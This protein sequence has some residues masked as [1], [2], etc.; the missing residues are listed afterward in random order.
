ML[1]HSVGNTAV[2]QSQ[3]NS[4]LPRKELGVSETSNNIFFRSYFIILIVI[5]AVEISVGLGITFVPLFGCLGKI[6]SIIVYLAER[7]SF[8]C[9]FVCLF[10]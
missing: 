10:V 9:L 5:N 3:L 4:K 7:P 1:T 8:V 2:P 6:C